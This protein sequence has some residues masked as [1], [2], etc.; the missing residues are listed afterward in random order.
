M[1]STIDMNVN[2]HLRKK[3]IKSNKIERY[4]YFIIGICGKNFTGPNCEYCKPGL[5]GVRCDILID[6]CKPNRCLN[7]GTCNGGSLDYNCTCLPGYTGYDCEIKI[8]P[9]ARFRAVSIN[10]YLFNLV[11]N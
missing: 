11:F 7:G 6:M 4:V 10:T 8:D 2:K 1:I 5:T 3:R 9:C